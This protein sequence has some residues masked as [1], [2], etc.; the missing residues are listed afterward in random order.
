M[1]VL[2][3]LPLAIILAACGEKEVNLMQ[4]CDQHPQFCA[5]LWDDSH[6][7]DE[8][9][10]VIFSRVAEFKLPSDANKYQLLMDFERYHKCMELAAGIEHIKLKEKTTERVKNL[11]VA[12]KEIK[13]LSAETLNS[14]HPGLAFYH[15]SREHSDAHLTKFL[16]AAKAGELKTPDLMFAYGQYLI[17]RDTDQAI[18][19]ILKALSL[20]KA[21]QK[22]DVD[23][24]TS[25]TTL[26]FK[27][28]NFAASYHWALVS[29]NAG[30]QRI[31]FQ[32]ILQDLAPQV[33]KDKLEA[34]ADQTAL[35]LSEGTF[36][37]PVY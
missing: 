2:A 17:D 19:T 35:T 20:Y 24:Y 31:E 15:W 11:L 13:R 30:V 28:Q 4:L 37:P 9:R 27:K 26:Y 22:I 1:K 5:D 12:Q 18:E 36:K 34:L 21:G 10:T 14:D 33:D 6:C 8:R 7:K 29:K 16:R 25:L 32:R 3:I 23:M